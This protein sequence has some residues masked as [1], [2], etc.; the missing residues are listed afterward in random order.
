M[1]KDLASLGIKINRPF[2]GDGIKIEQVIDKEIELLD[3][4]VRPSDKKPNTDYVKMQ[5]RV[6]GRKRFIGGG[7]KY[8]C[9]VLHLIDKKELP[10]T[11]IIRSK[12][13]YYFEGTINET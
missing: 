7:Y 2:E 5:I 12:Q 13:G 9:E 4:E 10:L 11:T 1:A 8:L 6:D 3:F